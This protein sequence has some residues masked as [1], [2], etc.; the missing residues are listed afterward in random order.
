[1]PSVGA[2][3]ERKSGAAAAKDGVRVSKLRGNDAR[4]AIPAYLQAKLKIGADDDAFEQQ[5]DHVAEKIIAP[6]ASGDEGFEKNNA[7]DDEVVQRKKNPNPVAMTNKTA[8]GVRGNGAP[9]P[10]SIRAQAEPRL[11]ADFSG[12]RV[13][14]DAQAQAAAQSLQAK[15]FTR[16]SD[17]VFASG[18]YAPD[19]H[20][21]QKLLA[22]EL[23]HVVQQG[24]A[25]SGE[26]TLG[27]TGVVEKDLG[28]SERAPLVQRTPDDCGSEAAA[29]VSREAPAVSESVSSESAAVAPEAVCSEPAATGGEPGAAPGTTAST[30]P[31][32]DGAEVPGGA[33]V[34]DAGGAPAAGASGTA[35]TRGEGGEESGGSAGGGA[36]AEEEGGELITAPAF[37]TGAGDLG[38][39]DLVLIDVELAE[40]QRWAGALGRVGEVAS[41]QRAEFIAEA[42]GGSFISGAASGLTMGLAIGLTTRAIPA[43]GPVIGGALALHGLVTRDWAETGATIGRFGEGSDTYEMLA[44]SIASVSA[45]I[46]VV[47]NILNVINGIVGVVQVAALVIAGGATVAAFFTFGATAGIAVAAADVAAVCEEI[48]LGITAVTTVLDGVN[49]SILAPAVL[50]FNALHAFTTQADPREVEAQGRGISNAAA[51]SGAA[52][53]AWVGGKAAHAGARARPPEEAPPQQRPPHETPPPAAGEGPVVRFQEPAVPPH[54]EGVSSPHTETAAAPAP[55]EAPVSGGRRV[56]DDQVA[57]AG[58]EPLPASNMSAPPANRTK[59]TEPEVAPIRTD[60]LADLAEAQRLASG[61]PLGQP[62][63]GNLPGTPGRHLRRGERDPGN[64]A[65]PRSARS[66]LARESRAASMKELGEAVASGTDTP[67]TAAAR[68][69]LTPDQQLLLTDPTVRAMDPEGARATER[70]VE[71]SHVPAV[72]AEPHGAHTAANVE[73]LPT[74]VHREGIHGGDVTR[75]L[76]TSSP[77]PSYEGRP[78]F[79]TMPGR[80]PPSPS[81]DAGMLRGALRDA[82]HLEAN[83]PGASRAEIE[84]ARQWLRT[85][86]ASPRRVG[87]GA[88]R[89][90]RPLTDAEFQRYADMAES[91]GMPREQIHRAQGDTAYHPGFDALLLGPDVNPLPLSERPVGL[92]NPANAAIEPRA[93]IGHEVIGHR[94][95]ELMGQSRADP[96]HEELQASARAALHTPELSSEQR[97]ILLQDA[98]A[99]RRFQTREGE[100]YINT[101]RYGAVETPVPSGGRPEGHFR[102]QDQQPSVI[103]DWDALGLPPPSNAATTT[104]R[105]VA[106]VLPARGAFTPPPAL[107]PAWAAGARAAR[108]SE[109]TPGGP[110]PGPGEP[111]FGT[112]ARQVGELFLPQLFGPSGHAPTYAERQAAHRARFTEENQ[113]MEGVE[114]INPNYPPP[115]ATPA[116]IT[117]IQN[118]IINLLAARARVEQEVQHQSERADQCVENEAPIQQTVDDTASGIAATQAHD[119]AVARRTAANQEQQQRQQESQGLTA[120]YPSR[121]T[122]LLVLSGPLAAWEGFTDLA[123]HLPG[124]AGDKMTQMNRE[125]RQMQQTF[126]Q[127]G[128][129]MLGINTA[130][131]VQQ[132]GLQGDAARLDATGVQAEASQEYLQTASTGAQGLQEAN[133]ATMDEANRAHDHATDQSAQLGDAVT[134]RETQAQSLADQLSAWAVAHRQARQQAIQATELRL[135][136]EGRIVVSSSEQ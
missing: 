89:S 72:A 122:G 7:A 125:A 73:I 39:S 11:G 10:S 76:E 36:V 75:P 90:G 77:N 118:E 52:L 131:P 58:I 104:S 112:R 22:H 43:V 88:T 5:A 117:A 60:V 55:V 28:A 25:G 45:A 56:T 15:A 46:D 14:T 111:T 91:M 95:A 21:G 132:A 70:A 65:V 110:Q 32:G 8:A 53:G 80:K 82:A 78:G 64:Y 135:R 40:H 63:L 136:G 99:R 128:A 97:W 106:P 6:S 134:E 66:R 102:A 2:A 50:L 4:A 130:Q 59:M 37:E 83:F 67:R 114:R 29:P 68:E 47:S 12:V 61:A 48:S 54:R 103:V 107:F 3:Q 30:A 133:Q 9:L 17:I 34:P 27:T 101:E 24:A 85:E 16:G 92:V 23:T 108:M 96:W 81:S 126:D 98:A 105:A 74:E 31:G 127:M 94:E 13:H 57:A 113:P 51:L 38:M 20:D 26:M 87:E 62:E 120:G 115:P 33:E 71:A 109:P 116:Q 129:H 79:T 41:L 124:S 42:A 86:L 19:T 69:T 93:A 1:M 123:S 121:A 49:A 84:A 35:E 18:E 44:N 100:I 119:A